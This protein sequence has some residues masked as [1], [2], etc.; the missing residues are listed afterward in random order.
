MHKRLFLIGGDQFFRENVRKDVISNAPK[1]FNLVMCDDPDPDFLSNQINS[2]SLFDKFKVIRVRNFTLKKGQDQILKKFFELSEVECALVIEE[3]DTKKYDAILKK[4]RDIPGALDYLAEFC[5]EDVSKPQEIVK[6]I[7]R[8]ADSI[9]MDK[10]AAE[11]LSALCGG[12]LSIIQSEIKKLKLLFDDGPVLKKDVMWAV[13]RYDAGGEQLD[14]YLAIMYGNAALAVTNC[15]AT[16]KELGYDAAFNTLMKLAEAMIVIKSCKGDGKRAF[17]FVKQK[18]Q[19]IAMTRCNKHLWGGESATEKNPPTP[20]LYKV[21]QKAYDRM[22]EKGIDGLFVR[23]IKSS[24]EFRRTTNETL[25]S[26]Q[27]DYFASV[28]CG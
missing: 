7:L 10:E 19:P 12:D 22:D 6:F 5:M 15:R 26:A 25:A 20:F 2:S 28:M 8:E 1:D 18:R 9:K 23:I 27:I 3:E 14:I 21:A 4:L 16:T 11:C 13:S 24:I 17:E